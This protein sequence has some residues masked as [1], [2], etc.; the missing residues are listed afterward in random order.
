MKWLRVRLDDCSRIVGG[1]TPSTSIPHYWDGDICWATPKDLSELD[2]PYLDTT[3]RRIT[4]EGLDS[5]AAE[6]LPADSV[7]FSSRAPI[8]HVAINRVPMATNQGFKSF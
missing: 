2:G 4:P 3:P 1:A 6:V 7:L 8:G 5:C